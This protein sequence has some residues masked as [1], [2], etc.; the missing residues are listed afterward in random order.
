MLSLSNTFLIRSKRGNSMLGMEQP[1][2]CYILFIGKKIK[3]VVLYENEKIA[4]LKKN[5]DGR[6][7]KTVFR[8]AISSY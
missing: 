4:W 5:T 7:V 8:P 2:H 1:D 3:A 6:A